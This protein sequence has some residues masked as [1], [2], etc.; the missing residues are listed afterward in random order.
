MSTSTTSMLIGIV[1]VTRPHMP[2]VWIAADIT[3]DL[4]ISHV[5]RLT[6]GTMSTGPVRGHDV[7]TVGTGRAEKTTTLI[8]AIIAAI[9]L[10]VITTGTRN[11][12][13]MMICVIG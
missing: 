10:I 8:A 2:T 9:G 6:A 1:I 7:R 4:T 3:T 5:I 11:S 12:S 13:K